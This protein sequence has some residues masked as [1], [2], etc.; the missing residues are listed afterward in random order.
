MIH[1][2]ATVDV[3]E[4]KRT[5]FLNEFQKVIPHVRA[6]KGCIEYGPAIDFPSGIPVQAP[7]REDCVVIIEKWSDIEALKGHLVAPHMKPYRDG[8][9]HI[10]KGMTVQILESA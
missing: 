6:E 10:V 3:A 7:V 9:K 5:D 1:V 8:V 2:I 4:G